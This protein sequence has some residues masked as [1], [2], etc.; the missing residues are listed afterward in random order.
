MLTFTHFHVDTRKNVTGFDLDTCEN[1]GGTVQAPNALQ[2]TA[3]GPDGLRAMGVI[4]C[5]AMPNETSHNDDLGHSDCERCHM[6]TREEREWV[7][8]PAPEWD[9]VTDR[10]EDGDAWRS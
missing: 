5:P 4:Q 7:T 1:C 3:P 10:S 6:P 8:E 9:G 2:I